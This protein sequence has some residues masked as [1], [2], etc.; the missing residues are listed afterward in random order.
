MP[1]ERSADGVHPGRR[2]GRDDLEAL[3]AIVGPGAVSVDAGD[4][5][6]Y[7]T[8]R[9]VGPWTADAGA[10]VRPKT[11]VEVRAVVRCCE[12][13]G[14]PIVP[15][16]GRT[17][18]VGGAVATAG[19]VVVSLDRMRAVLDVDPR[20]RTVRCEAGATVAAVDEAARA[21][22]LFYPV[23]FAAKGTAQVGG[24]IATNAGGV[25]VVRYGSTR[26]WVRGLVLV[27]GGGRV[28]RLG[29]GL[30]KDNTG[31]ALE[32]LVV[33]AEGTLGI[34]VEATLGL[35]V[36]PRAVAVGVVGAASVEA[37]LGLYERLSSARCTVSA[38]ECFD[39]ACLGAVLRARGEIRP[40]L[41][42]TAPMYG[43]VE[44]EHDGDSAE[45]ALDA[46]AE[47]LCQA[48]E[49]GEIS[50]ATM[51]QTPAQ[52]RALWSLRESVSEALHP[53]RPHKADVTLPQRA[54]GDFLARARALVERHV[55]QGELRIFGHLG[56]GNLHVNLLP[57]RDA[58]LPA[59]ALAVFDE[60]LYGLV[61]DLGGS[62]S[63]EHGV[64]LLKRPYLS[65]RR[66]PEELALM[67]AVKA[68]FDPAG[69]F[70]PG[71][72]LPDAGAS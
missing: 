51:A 28:L 69:V 18:L 21:H 13:R 14:L 42:T 65:L 52:A 56:D 71:K 39:E 23:D 7:G 29:R 35:A 61:S 57:P 70:N 36:P 60:A 25:R 30:V 33:G 31:Y 32:H 59:S 16:G 41:Q 26:S 62:L 66:T 44:I 20:A 17:G 1:N 40:P 11:L 34:V 12:Q 58:D 63:A 43:L 6:A 45:A 15:S 38:F 37:L 19:E 64:G 50:D 24:T 3:A 5:A 2:P 68:A 9:A 4:R 46:L 48:Q 47:V 55:S 72:L 54:M 22:G 27:T 49:A 67:R 8:D 10:V 53:R